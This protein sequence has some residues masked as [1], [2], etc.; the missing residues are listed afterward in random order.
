MDKKV[1]NEFNIQTKNKVRLL[2]KISGEALKDG[3]DSVYSLRKINLLCK[4]IKFLKER[5]KNLEV[6]VVLGGGNI[7]RGEFE[8]KNLLL[9]QNSADNVG[10]LATIMNTII[11]V[12]RLSSFNLD[13][14]STSS[15]PVKNL[16]KSYLWEE[17]DNF[18]KRNYLVIFAGGIGF[19][20]FSTDT[21][22][23]L[24]AKQIG[25][26]LLLVG[27]N[28][29]D[30]VYDKDPKL[31]NDA[32]KFQQLTYSKIIK[33]RIRVMDLT[34]MVFA[35]ERKLET[36][37]FDINNPKGIINAYLAPETTTIIK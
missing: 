14:I 20:Y 4:Q 31:H 29:V 30:G 10:I 21:T 13:V 16:I 1:P 2:I 11:L 15:I 37:V 32:V 24:R 12:E 9:N 18:L 28:G 34:S 8:K 35:M 6:G 25:A 5:D 36:R 7:F 17:V 22:A 33:D 19:P 27:K 26:D 3:D 23:V